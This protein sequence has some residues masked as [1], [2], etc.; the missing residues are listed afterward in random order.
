VRCVVIGTDLF[1]V[2]PFGRALAP[3]FGVREV[4]RLD[5][6]VGVIAEVRDGAARLEVEVVGRLNDRE[7]AWVAT[8]PW[9]GACDR[10]VEGAG[11][12]P[13]ESEVKL[14]VRPVWLAVSTARGGWW[15]RVER[16][17]VNWLA[18]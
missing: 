7:D 6:L 3:R 5:T 14:I 15:F 4:E 2:R 11:V 16:L 12:S 13:L 1:G 17:G 8:T 18:S 9:L 10:W